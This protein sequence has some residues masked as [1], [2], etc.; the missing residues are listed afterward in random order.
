MS[1]AENAGDAR[2]ERTAVCREA[3]RRRGAPFF[4]GGESARIAEV[5]AAGGDSDVVAAVFALGAHALI[6]PPNRRMEKQDGLDKNLEEIDER[7]EAADVRQFVCDDGF[8]LIFREAS[9]SANRKQ[10]DGLEPADDG[11]GIEPAA[12]A[13]ANDASDA[14]TRLQFAAL[15]EKRGS[16]GN[17]SGTAQTFEIE[18]PARGTEREEENAREPEFNEERQRLCGEGFCCGD[19]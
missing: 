5:I 9:E 11:R 2:G 6:Q 1:Q 13:E 18:Q 15:C 12:F 16:D 8:D 4:H 14:E 17:G 10:H 3:E 7:V 19:S